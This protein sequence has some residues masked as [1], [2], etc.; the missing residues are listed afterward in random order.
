M[1][2]KYKQIANK[3]LFKNPIN[4]LKFH[5]KISGWNLG[6]EQISGQ[7]FLPWKYRLVK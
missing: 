2:E 5:T 3:L 6:I 1:A 7:I 4:V